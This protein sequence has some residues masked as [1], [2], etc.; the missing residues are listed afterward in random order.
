MDKAISHFRS[1]VTTLT[2]LNPNPYDGEAF[3][4]LGLA[5]RH[6]GQLAEAEEAF[7]KAAWSKAWRGPAEFARAQLAAQCG[8]Y[9]EAITLLGTVIA[10]DPDQLTARGLRAAI[11]RRL[12]DV[13]ACSADVAM[14]LAADP[15]DAIALHLRLLMDGRRNGHLPGG[16]QTAL[17]VAHDYAAA[18][19]LE[20]GIDVLRRQLSPGGAAAAAHPMLRYTLAW[21]L[22]QAGDPGFTEELKLATEMPPDY[23]FPSRLEEIAVLEA[24]MRCV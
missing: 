20:E 19:L 7:A 6:G 18:G 13:G 16:A 14:V 11:W 1:A 2:R 5:L 22:H 23:C 24:A 12:G 21:L 9:E 8:G 10:A 3:Y 4:G 17:D 15:L